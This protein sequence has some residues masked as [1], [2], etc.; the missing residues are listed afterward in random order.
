MRKGW[1]PAE[2]HFLWRLEDTPLP[3]SFEH[4]L[5]KSGAG[6]EQY[7]NSLQVERENIN[8]NSGLNCLIG[9]A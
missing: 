1:V 6:A 8:K 4:S 7:M 3:Q 5:E 2:G 9:V